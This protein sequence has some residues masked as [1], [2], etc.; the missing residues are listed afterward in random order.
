M[1][2]QWVFDYTTDDPNAP[3][4]SG[5]AVLTVTGTKSIQGANATV[6]SRQDSTNPAGNYDEYFA[7]GKGGVTALGNTDSSDT[8]SPLIIPYVQLLF[9]VGIGPVSTVTGQNLP[10]GTNAS[11]GPVTLN[12][13]QVIANTARETVDVPAGTFVNAVKQTT[14]VNATVYEGGQ[15][16]PITGNEATWYAAGV[17][18]IKDQTSA[19]GA[20]T[21]LTTS[22]ELRRYLINGLWHGIGASLDIDS[23]LV[24]TGCEGSS[25]PDPAVSSDG[26][27]FLI[28]AFACST[29]SGA[30]LSNWVAFL[31]SP[32]GTV[33]NTVDLT[34]PAANAGT[35]VYLH[36]V[37][38]FDGTNYLIVYE[39]TSSSPSAIPLQSVVLSANGS[40]TAGPVMVATVHVAQQLPAAREALGFDGNRFLLIYAEGGA[41]PLVP[42]MSGLFITPG[43]GQAAGS[44]FTVSTGEAG[45]SS[46]AIAFDGTNY[47]VTW[48]RDDTSPLGL[49]A[50]RVTPAGA[51]MDATPIVLA[52]FSM[53]VLAEPCCDLEPTLSFDGTNYL[54]AY[55]DP[56]GEPGD[57][58]LN[59]AT[60]SAARVSTAGVLLDGTP[61]APG[62]V[63][64]K[65]KSVPRGRVRSVFLGGAHW[66]IWETNS[67]QQLNATRVTP[68]GV[69]ASTWTDGFAIVPATGLP[70]LPALAG[71]SAGALLVWLQ[72]Q[73]N[74]SPQS[75]LTGLR[76]Y[77]P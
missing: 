34:T 27:N 60:V 36:A 30:A 41:P 22:S 68:A 59:Y 17:G 1:Q 10:Y 24:T 16:A 26:T 39:D 55:R 58:A 25:R 14:T 77:P 4:A 18:Q 3:A 6:F 50:M 56:R 76:I 74:Q 75:Q 73:S 61:T 9:P 65:S 15:S 12:L 43:T 45:T 72:K 40:V 66:V 51:L 20:G 19:S 57:T 32:D 49:H 33:L 28:V 48:T 42:G 64:A 71:S 54:V 11:N 13:T 44:A 2:D 52:D 62:I 53:A 63:L 35:Q 8:I 67:S 69:A 23:T 5:T 29:A 7:V 31:V 47:F 37:S 70:Q 46:P 21:T 38:A